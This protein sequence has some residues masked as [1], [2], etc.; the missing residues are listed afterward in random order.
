MTALQQ[1]QLFGKIPGD[2]RKC[3]QPESAGL[4]H[5]KKLGAGDNLGDQKRQIAEMYEQI[6]LNVPKR[7]GKIALKRESD[8]SDT[9]A[10]FLSQNFSQN[11]SKYNEVR[12]EMVDSLP[13]EEVQDTTEEFYQIAQNVPGDFQRAEDAGEESRSSHRFNNGGWNEDKSYS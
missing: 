2:M 6:L 4:P 5:L 7:Q 10:R 12:P 8:G 1:R 3:F 9:S 11:E 13:Q